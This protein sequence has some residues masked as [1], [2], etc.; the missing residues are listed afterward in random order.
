MVAESS[1][2][3]AAMAA[4]TWARRTPWLHQGHGLVEGALDVATL[5][6]AGDDAPHRGASGFGAP[7]HFVLFRHFSAASASGAM[8]VGTPTDRCAAMSFCMACRPEMVPIR[9]IELVEVAIE[10]RAGGRTVL[11]RVLGLQARLHAQ[12]GGVLAL[13]S[14]GQPA[15]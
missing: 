7:H 13:G 10:V 2:D 12:E 5:A 6:R 14:Q 3:W 8:S 4:I 15:L 1:D 9:Y 11:E